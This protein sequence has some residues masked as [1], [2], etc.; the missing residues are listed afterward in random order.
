MKPRLLVIDD[1]P[2]VLELVK[3]LLV[4][5]G[6]AVL[7]ATSG[8]EGLRLAKA[9]RPEM[10]LL[11]QAMP[12]M[13]GETTVRSLKSDEATRRIPVIALSA[14][15]A[16]D[17][18]RAG[19]LACIPKPVHPATFVKTVDQFLRATT[20]RHGPSR[21]AGCPQGTVRRL[22]ASSPR[23]LIVED[24][25]DAAEALR[26]ELTARGYVVS[27]APTDRSA[28]ESVA[29]DVPDLVVLDLSDVAGVIVLEQLRAHRPTLP[30]VVV[31]GTQDEAVAQAALARGAM[32]YVAKPI[33]I[34]LLSQ[35]IAVA[36]SLLDR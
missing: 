14:G 22:Q 13:D 8:Q 17:A 27:L 11:D 19:C 34:D 23:I 30:V 31:S 28:L 1:E 6:Y 21:G 24:I 16:A 32:G 15:R 20:R 25:R 3:E 18:V 26:E 33:N 35:V 29:Q 12:G 10:I 2:L 5:A 4:A 9:Q 36:L 7:T